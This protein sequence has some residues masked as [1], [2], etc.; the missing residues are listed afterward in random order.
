[1]TTHFIPEKNDLPDTYL[2]VGAGPAGLV[3]ARA[4]M[5]AGIKFDI[6]E[7]YHEVGGIWNIE[8]EG[9]P[10][11]KSCNFIASKK[12]GGFIG[13]PM[14]DHF[15][16]FPKWTEIREYIH[17]MARDYG[18][19]RQVE[20][21]R[22]VVS[23]V[24]QGEGASTVWNVAFKNGET[25]R[26]RGVIYAGGHEWQRYMPEIDGMETFEGRLIHSRDYHSTVEFDGKR[27]LVIGAGNSGVDISSDAA[28]AADFAALSTRRGYWFLPKQ[29]FGVPITEYIDGTEELPA[30]FAG[31]DFDERIEVLLSLVGD[32]TRF[33]LPAPDHQLTETHPIVSNTVLHNL[34]HGRLSWRPDVA[35]IDGADVH[36]KDGRVEQYDVI[37][38]ATGY[39]IT[40][41]FVPEDLLEYRNGRPVTHL[42]TFFPG[43]DGL[44]AVGIMHVA[45]NGYQNFDEFS[46]MIVADIKATLTGEN[47]ENVRILKEEYRPDLKKGINLVDTRRNENQY[48]GP[49]MHEMLAHV[50]SEFGIVIPEWHDRA[51]YADLLV[52]ADRR[53]RVMTAA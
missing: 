39:D 30:R 46:Q 27:V 15:M 18:I 17:M 32:L 3:A 21:G 9:S 11:Y 48:S 1:M 6:V 44:Y 12:R 5:R 8:N 28:V 53:A 19:D 23:A 45:D 37:V 51:F 7:K 13:Y 26:Y 52:D 34:S 43:V 49:A 41:D 36:F 29:V 10:M 25:R 22:E 2:I 42:S 24:P 14:P 16:D 35:K 50:Q 40:V 33:G 31:M 4:F 38:C 20:F 47:A